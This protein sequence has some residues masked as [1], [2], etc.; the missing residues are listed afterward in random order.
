[1]GKLLKLFEILRQS[2]SLSTL[3]WENLLNFRNFLDKF[4]L[5]SL[6]GHA[7]IKQHKTGRGGH[8]IIFDSGGGQAKFALHNM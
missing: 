5:K 4:F 6:K 1:M 8:I 3:K 7:Y 2:C